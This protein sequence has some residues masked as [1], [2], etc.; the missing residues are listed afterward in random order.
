[1]TTEEFLRNLPMLVCWQAQHSDPTQRCMALFNTFT[2]LSQHHYEARNV[3]LARKCRSF[4]TT[5]QKPIGLAM[6]RL[7]QAPLQ[8]P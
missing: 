1:M 3:L 4:A 8:A 2:E 7:N 5:T 6:V